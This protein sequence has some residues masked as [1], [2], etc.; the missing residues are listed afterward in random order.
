MFLPG[1]MARIFFVVAET[2]TAEEALM[3]AASSGLFSTIS[4]ASLYN[5]FSTSLYSIRCSIL[6]VMVL[7]SYSFPCS[8]KEKLSVGSTL[9]SNGSLS[10]I[11]L[12]Q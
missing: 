7:P 12:K 10:R 9:R 5:P 6:H 3:S 1:E 8:L 4:S 11:S 2:I